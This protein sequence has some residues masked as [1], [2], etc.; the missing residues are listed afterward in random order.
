MDSEN[1]WTGALSWAAAAWHGAVA[2]AG[3]IAFILGAGSTLLIVWTMAS[4]L[5]KGEEVA[6]ALLLLIPAAL[7]GAFA[8]YGGSVAVANAAGARRINRGEAP[9]SSALALTSNGPLVVTILTAC[10]LG[11]VFIAVRAKW[12]IDERARTAEAGVRPPPE[13]GPGRPPGAHRSLRGVSRCPGDRPAAAS[14]L[15]PW[16][17]TR[18]AGAAP[19]L[20]GLPAPQRVLAK[21]SPALRLLRINVR[22]RPRARPDLR[23]WRLPLAVRPRPSGG[24]TGPAF[25]CRAVKTRGRRRA[26]AFSRRGPA[27]PGPRPKTA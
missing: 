18:R 19:A 10:A 22:Q 4:L 7:Y 16:P 11:V 21:Y 12:L 23:G 24:L 14:L 8:A 25:R 17:S 27:R 2:A 20:V 6:F 5:I 1:P 9:A 15:R 26:G 3:G 13:E